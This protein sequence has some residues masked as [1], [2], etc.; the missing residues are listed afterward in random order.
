[1]ERLRERNVILEMKVR[2]VVVSPDCGPIERERE[3]ERD[4]G[5]RI[6]RMGWRK[7]AKLRLRV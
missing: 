5:I 4:R 2:A 6:A 1:M 7:W 3:R